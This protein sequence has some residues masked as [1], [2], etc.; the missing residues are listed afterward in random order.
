MKLYH[1]NIFNNYI[2]IYIAGVLLVNLLIAIISSVYEHMNTVVDF[3][4][5]DVLIQYY[6]TYKWDEIL[7]SYFFSS[8]F[9]ILLIVLL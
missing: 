3:S 5:R 9:N 2:G 7:L 6:N 4:H 1:F 8:L